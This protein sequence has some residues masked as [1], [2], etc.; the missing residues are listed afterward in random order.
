MLQTLIPYS[1]L[2]EWFECDLRLFL[3]SIDFNV[4]G[5]KRN[6]C[7][8]MVVRKLEAVEIIEVLDYFM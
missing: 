8:V 1:G 2:G 5:L 3:G 6:K 7:L 4:R